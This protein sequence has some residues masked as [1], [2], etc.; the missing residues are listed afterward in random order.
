MKNTINHSPI[1]YSTQRINQRRRMG[2]VSSEGRTVRTRISMSSD[3]SHRLFP[4]SFP[5]SHPHSESQPHLVSSCTIQV[6]NRRLQTLPSP[7]SPPLHASPQ[8]I[9]FRQHS[10][11]VCQAVPSFPPYTRSHSIPPIAA[12]ADPPSFSH[13]SLAQE[14]YRVSPLRYRSRALIIHQHLSPFPR[15]EGRKERVA[16]LS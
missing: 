3:N 5:L 16:Y 8:P 14:S 15:P 1:L 7:S 13:A 10:N 9:V 4:S 6:R 12:D 11:F 2:I